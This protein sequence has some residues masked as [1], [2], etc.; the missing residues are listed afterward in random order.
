MALALSLALAGC[1]GEGAATPTT[2]P[3]VSPSTSPTPTPSPTPE[4]PQPPMRP[5]AMATNDEA[6]AVAAAQYF[7]TDLYDYMFA[8]GD[9]TEWSALSDDGCNFCNSILAKSQEMTASGEVAEADPS[10][11][12]ATEVVTLAEGSRYAVT[13]TLHQGASRTLD[14]AGAVVGQSTA[15]RYSVN[16]AIMRAADWSILAV[17]ATPLTADS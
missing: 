11:V 5:E 9:V 15:G 6:G 8:S 12:E 7:I 17:D 1:T 14:R 10:T 13:I 16:F 2:T 4:T 3:T